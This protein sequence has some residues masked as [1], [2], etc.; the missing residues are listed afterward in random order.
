MDAFRNQAV[1]P[2]TARLQGTHQRRLIRL[3]A[4][5]AWRFRLRVGLTIALTMGRMVCLCGVFI[6][7]RHVIE[8]LQPDVGAPDLEA[9]FWMSGSLLCF[10]LAA[11][12]CQYFAEETQRWF[13]EGV[14]LETLQWTLQHLILLPAD[15]FRTNSLARFAMQ[16]EQVQ[17]MVRA[18]V[19]GVFNI[20]T[21][22]AV[23]VGV[24]AAILPQQM[25]L[26]GLG[27]GVLAGIA[28]VVVC[29]NV[30]Y[31]HAV[32]AETNQAICLADDT[33]GMFANLRDLHNF[34]MTTEAVRHFDESCALLA[35]RSLNVVKAQRRAGAWLNLVG[36]VFLAA[37]AG[38][39]MALGVS[40]AVA[41]TCFAALGTLLEP[42]TEI[43]YAVTPLLTCS[44]HLTALF[45]IIHSLRCEQQ[46]SGKRVLED[47]VH[48]LLLEN[49]SYE[50]GGHLILDAINLRAQRGSIVGIMGRSGAGKTTLANLVLQL[51]EPTG[52]RFLVNGVDVQELDL[53]SYWRQA[54]AVLQ[55]PCL[56]GG[57]LAQE[58]SLARPD[59]TPDE[60]ERAMTFAGIDASLHGA[61]LECE[62]PPSDASTDSW[63][64]RS[65]QQRLEWARLAVRPAHLVVLDEPT[66]LADAAQEQSFTRR[67]LER[68]QDRITLL[69]SHRPMT[70]AVCDRLLVLE[71]GRAVAEGP[72][73]DI[74]PR[75]L[76][77]R[78]PE[79]AGA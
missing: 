6:C 45:A 67:L 77:E 61:G 33:L 79:R 71:D 35:A 15:Y 59:A 27:F 7:L 47:P 58:V 65:L 75:W 14:E 49:V 52:G 26:A 73:A 11:I 74:L 19:V 25:M 24:V 18:T 57:T 70:L 9:F 32:D 20:G 63:H 1:T 41:L 3:L 64:T 37:A 13:L 44:K 28:F 5:F 8:S 12:V 21:R 10:Q 23:I 53:P 43:V 66:S 42:L 16:I 51:I 46:H 50:R 78:E 4:H 30:Q 48:E 39:L 62:G 38:G 60:I 22:G 68:R 76:P 56:L 31:Q 29:R 72:P 54:T 40:A 36:I 17:T 34:G 55:T 2:S 69:F